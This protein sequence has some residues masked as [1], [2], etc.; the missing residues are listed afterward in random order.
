MAD[1][2]AGLH[3]AT[4]GLEG[5]Q[6]D[7]AVPAVQGELENLDDDEELVAKLRSQLKLR[8]SRLVDG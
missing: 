7:G 2:G 3:P 8:L 6:A 5:H 1:V 4:A